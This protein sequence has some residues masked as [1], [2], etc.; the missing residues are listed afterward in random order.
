MSKTLKNIIQFILFL[1]FGVLLF[2][3]VYKDTNWNNLVESLKNVNY[4]WFIPIFIAGLMSHVSRAIRWNMLIEPLG[5]KTRFWNT[6]FAV[7]TGYF[8]N[9]AIPRLGEVARCG[10]VSKYDNV[11]ISKVLGTMITE[12]VID[13]ITLLLVVLIALIVE[14]GFFTDFLIQNPEIG[15]NIQNMMNPFILIIILVGILLGIVLFYLILKG[16]FDRFGVFLKLKNFVRNLYIGLLSVRI[17][18]RKFWFLFHSILIW[19]LYYLMMV[20]AFPAFGFTSELGLSA[21]LMVFVAGSFGMIA[22]APNG[23][24]AYHFMVIQSLLI[25]GVLKE[26]AAV[27][28]FVVHGLQTLMLLLAGL[29]SLVALPLINKYPTS[30][31]ATKTAL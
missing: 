27:F 26:N 18:K 19:V 8:A 29:L 17:V 13:I 4:W 6:F 1:G 10:V 11:P 22:P 2:W 16:K 24:G 23:M 12:R 31:S 20:F 7:M 30:D 21:A 5:Y 9:L 14:S 3:L 15:E 28:A 25:F